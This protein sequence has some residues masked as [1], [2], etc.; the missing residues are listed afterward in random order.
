[1]PVGALAYA[2]QQPAVQPVSDESNPTGILGD[3][4]DPVDEARDMLL[5]AEW[6][7]SPG[8]VT[9]ATTFWI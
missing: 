9:D 6:V 1:M 3:Y 7:S 8:E 2:S 5:N 4:F